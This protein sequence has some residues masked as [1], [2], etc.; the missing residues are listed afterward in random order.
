MIEAKDF[1]EHLDDYIES[2]DKENHPLERLFSFD[3]FLETTI[4]QERLLARIRNSSEFKQK[5]KE[6]Q[7][8]FFK[9]IGDFFDGVLAN[10]A[11]RILQEEYKTKS[12]VIEKNKNEKKKKK[13]NNYKDKNKN[14]PSRKKFWI[15]VLILTVAIIVFGLFKVW[16]FAFLIVPI[17]L[18]II[19]CK[20]PNETDDKN[21][22]IKELPFAN[23]IGV[24]D[25]NRQNYIGDH[26]PHQIN[27]DG[28]QP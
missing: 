21:L 23:Q 15:G 2:G 22:D 13:D 14:A 19:L 20:K 5:S 4:K 17:V 12:E 6:D 10:D 18:S 25:P 9:Y 11:E 28:K 27:Q 3:Y 24:F 26:N 7:I 16:G 1:I 8:K